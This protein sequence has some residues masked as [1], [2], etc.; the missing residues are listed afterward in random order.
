MGTAV[1]TVIDNIPPTAITQN[2]SV[3]LDL[4]GNA[5]IMPSQIN[6]GSDDNCGIDTLTLNQ[7]NFNCTNIGT[8]TVTLTVTDTSGNSANATATVT[9][10][11]NI[12]PTVVTQNISVNL[13]ATGNTV[14]TANQIDNGSF[15]NCG[16]A[17]LTLDQSNFDC[18]H[19]GSNTVTLTIT[20]VNGNI[21]SATAEVTVIDSIAPNVMTISD[22]LEIL[23]GTNGH[24]SISA[25][26]IDAGSTD[27]CGISSIRVSP[28]NFG[29]TNIGDNIVTLTVTDLSGNTNTGS[30]IVRILPIPAPTTSQL[31]QSFCK[32]DQPTI[33]DISVNEPQAV[34]FSSMGASQ[35]V[36]TSTILTTGTYYVALRYGSCLGAERIAINIV[37]NDTPQPTGDAI[38]YLCWED[39]PTIEDIQ[40]NENDVIWYPSNYSN[41]AITPGTPIESGQIYYGSRLGTDCESSERF[42]VK[43]IV[44]YCDAFVHNALTPNGDGKNDVLTIRGIENFPENEL[45]IFNR[46]GVSVFQSKGYGHGPIAFAGIANK[47]PNL[48]IGTQLLPSGTYFYILNFINFDGIRISKSGYIHLTY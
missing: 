46:Y 22:P 12:T 23:L 48:A 30:A 2:I 6:N 26:Q 32:I 38:Q 4:S 44:R 24:V 18:T 31:S 34:F 19:I 42:E 37:V 20:D 28:F 21:S 35:P 36:G 3:N 39:A 10:I 25:N 5:I 47:G 33:A 29:C 40:T 43:V 16:I 13:D 9:I 27:N 14:I 8:N 7:T 15:D 41:S 45:E 17:S 1:V 11:D